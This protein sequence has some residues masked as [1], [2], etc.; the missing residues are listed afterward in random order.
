MASWTY[1]K[2]DIEIV[3][4]DF[5]LWQLKKADANFTSERPYPLLRKAFSLKWL[6]LSDIQE[7]CRVMS[8]PI[9][10]VLR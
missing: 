6:D 8:I 9:E 7:I 4:D 10:Y 5:N 1:K 2:D 3:Y